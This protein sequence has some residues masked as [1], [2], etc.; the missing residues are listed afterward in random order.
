PTVLTQRLVL[1]RWMHDD[2]ELF[3]Q[4]NADPEVM[5]Y[6]FKPLTRHESYDLIDN[7]ES[8]FDQ[9]GFGQWAVE[10]IADQRVIGFIG[11]EVSDD[12][13][14]FS[15]PIHIGWHLAPDV[16]RCGYATEG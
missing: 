15:P 7:I 12:A 3:A 2:R 6:R 13:T 14:L 10:R 8:C 9:H 11:L 5:R 4:I 1:R 16:W